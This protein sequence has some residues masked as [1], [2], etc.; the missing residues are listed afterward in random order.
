MTALQYNERLSKLMSLYEPNLYLPR[1][2]HL[3]TDA[4]FES[5]TLRLITVRG[6]PPNASAQDN[7]DKEEA[8]NILNSEESDTNKYSQLDKMHA[9]AINGEL[10]G[11]TAEEGTCI[12]HIAGQLSVIPYMH[13]YLPFN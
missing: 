1:F 4:E 9:D 13:I 11:I 10:S 3:L 12:H 5:L 6:N 2:N 8:F 7:A